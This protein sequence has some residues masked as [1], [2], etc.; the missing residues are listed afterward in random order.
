MVY[1]F[2]PRTQ[3]APMVVDM[4]A[5]IGDKPPREVPSYAARWLA[6]FQGDAAGLLAAVERGAAQHKLKSSGNHLGMRRF[7]FSDG[8][9]LVFRIVGA[10]VVVDLE[11][12]ASLRAYFDSLGVYGPQE[13]LYIQALQVTRCATWTTF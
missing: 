1:R 9:M 12:S 10:P 6:K 8:S 4:E 7:E 5:I 13:A 11:D 3:R 2:K